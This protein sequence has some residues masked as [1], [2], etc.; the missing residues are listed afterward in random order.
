MERRCSRSVCKSVVGSA[1]A[2]RTPPPLALMMN[3]KSRRCDARR[4][5][6]APCQA[7]MSLKHRRVFFEPRASK[8]GERTAERP[9]KIFAA[10]RATAQGRS[11]SAAM[12][13]KLG[14]SRRH[15][16]HLGSRVNSCRIGR[17]SPT[18]SSERG[19]GCTPHQCG[20][21]AEAVAQSV[22]QRTFNP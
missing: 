17:F 7:R 13:H 3:S 2:P 6:Q 22:E 15:A 5:C 9:T 14:D 11:F 12:R 18:S 4:P 20:S 16:P 10:A 8:I 21:L 1:A 19:Q